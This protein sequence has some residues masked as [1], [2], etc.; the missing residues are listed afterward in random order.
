[1]TV[2]F[3]FMLTCSFVGLGPDSFNKIVDIRIAELQSVLDDKRITLIL[4]QEARDWLAQEGYSPVYGARALNR[5]VTKAVRSPIS[6]ALLRGTIRPGDDAVF[7]R[8]ESGIELV[9]QHPAETAR[10]AEIIEDDEDDGDLSD[11]GS[12]SSR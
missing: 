9:E 6:A 10:E 2:C 5:L 7:I 12:S 1:M 3:D 8:T 11:L 4:E